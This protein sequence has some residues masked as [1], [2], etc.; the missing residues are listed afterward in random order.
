LPAVFNCNSLIVIVQSYS[1][2]SGANTSAPALY[3]AQGNP[4]STW[5]YSPGAQGQV[6]VVQLVYPWSVVSGPLGFVLANL[7]NSA[8]EMMGVAAFR[9][10]PY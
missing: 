10:E 1:S 4:V 7:P 5:A 3:D 9:V 6:M 2:F 8:A